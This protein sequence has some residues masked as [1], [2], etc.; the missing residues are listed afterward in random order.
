MKG[1]PKVTQHILMELPFEPRSLGSKATLK[2]PS[3][4]EKQ[5][6]CT[7]MP[8]P[9]LFWIFPGLLSIGTYHF[10]VLASLVVTSIVCVA[11]SGRG[12][13]PG[14]RRLL[15]TVPSR[16][17]FSLPP[18]LPLGWAMRARPQRKREG[19]S[20][21]HRNGVSAG[22]WKGSSSHR[23]LTPIGHRAVC[24][25]HCWGRQGVLAMC[26]GRENHKSHD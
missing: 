20:T 2:H 22:N 24:P 21:G 11:E 12:Q 18:S 1:L 3:R 4:W 23:T 19:L 17:D 25:W 13:L 14:T 16:W 8:F 10:L 15:G 7:G 6:I 5:Q 26:T 9:A